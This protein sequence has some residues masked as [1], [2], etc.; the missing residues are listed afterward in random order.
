MELRH[1]RY[2]V[3][4]A[5]ALSFRRAADGLRLSHPALSKQ[6]RDLERDLGVALLRRSTTSVWLT[7]A[8]ERF[9][10]HARAILARVQE[11]TDDVRGA[12]QEDET[13]PIGMPGPF[14]ESVLPDVLRRFRQIRPGATV[15]VIAKRPRE[16]VLALQKGEVRLAFVGEREITPR[17]DL[18]QLRLLRSPFGVILARGHPLSARKTLRWADIAEE[19]LYCLYSG[20]G[21]P[22]LADMRLV[23]PERKPT[24]AQVKHVDGFDSLVTLVAAGHGITLLPRNFVALRRKLL[25]YRPLDGARADRQFELWALWRKDERSPLLRD[26]ITTLKALQPENEEAA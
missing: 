12:D 25:C 15:R 17:T 18:E 9:L 20:R 10:D 6:I 7:P 13:L 11:A 21:S 5:E 8:G 23:L 1:L 26:F 3:A 2:F 14:W 22:H 16:Q 4:V 19:N 24:P